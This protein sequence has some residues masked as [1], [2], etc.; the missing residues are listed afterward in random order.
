[1]PDYAEAY[2][3]LG[4]ALKELGR[5][6]EAVS[7]YEQ[8][9]SIRPDY[10]EAHINLGVSFHDQGRHLGRENDRFQ[11][12]CPALCAG[13]HALG[14]SPARPQRGGANPY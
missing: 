2:Y 3:N 6:E 10:A 1:M 4:N 11:Q 5:Y 12:T 8:T 13:L 9:L 7:R 14:R